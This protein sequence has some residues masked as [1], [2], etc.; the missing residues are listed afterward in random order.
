[1]LFWE[2]AIKHLG[3]RFEEI[4]G[5]IKTIFAPKGDAVVEANLRALQAGIEN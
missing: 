2:L 4:A 3:F 1:M 5:A